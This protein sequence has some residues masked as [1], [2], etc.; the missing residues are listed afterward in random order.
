MVSYFKSF[1]GKYDASNYRP[2][3][4]E[5]VKGLLIHLD[6]PNTEIQEAVQGRYS[7]LIQPW[8]VMKFYTLPLKQSHPQDLVHSH[9]YSYAT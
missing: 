2:H 5:L 8:K 3:F 7:L 4:E 9:Q 1:N 6:D